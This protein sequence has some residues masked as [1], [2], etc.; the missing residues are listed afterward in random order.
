VTIDV[1]SG[2]VPR[3]VLGKAVVAEEERRLCAR[4]AEQAVPREKLLDNAKAI[5]SSGV[6]AGFECQN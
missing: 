6:N 5:Y 3:N 4:E 2:L 1:S